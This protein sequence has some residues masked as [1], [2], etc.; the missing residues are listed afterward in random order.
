MI[1]R[2]TIVGVA[3]GTA[4]GGVAIVRLSG[5]RAIAI[6]EALGGELGTPRRLV[7]RSLSVGASHE[8]ALVVVMPAPAS[9][10]GED[11]VELHVHA[12]ARNVEQIVTACV[13]AGAVPAGA[14]AFSRRA[15][16]L[17]RLTLEQ[18]EGIAALIG[19]QTDAALDQARR[20]V[21]G[22]L[23]REVDAVVD[24]VVE[25]RAEI[26]ARLDFPEDVDGP[27]LER[28]GVEISQ[29]RGVIGDWLA[30]Y[31]AGAR[32]RTRPR[33][34]LAGPPN[35]G[36][37]SLFNALVGYAR[38]IV[39]PQPGTTRD[40]VEAEIELG[41]FACVVVDTA[42]LR[43]VVDA[44]ERAGVERSHEQIEGADLVL[45]IEAADAED[46]AVP[47]LAGCAVERIETKRD[48]ATRRSTWRGVSTRD[49][50]SVD[51]LRE[52]LRGAIVGTE[53]GWI[54][55]L[56]HRESAAAA[57]HELEI[58]AGKFDALELVAFH[59]GVAAD[60]LAEIRGRS[61]L[62]PIG[63]DVMARI[64]ARFCIGK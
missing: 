13:D 30:R 51:A 45:W 56:R 5:T 64:F 32:A 8:D 43:E 2:S 22:E 55:L 60:R 37:S 29:V 58:A 48:L 41:A 42:G 1:E 25:L 33:V 12:G 27:D 28:W 44:I 26:E 15:F 21:A 63:E 40:W 11:V 3:T 62:G 38:S 61:A 14:G 9:F 57:A 46:A 31:D 6:A 4:D 10:T 20:L 47:E 49:A 52:W 54:G 53:S 19:A 18:A 50:A 34:V 24:R 16:E 39:T 17:G 23:G 7:R 35:A 36:K 59:L